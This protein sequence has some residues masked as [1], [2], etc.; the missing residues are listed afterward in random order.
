MRRLSL[1]FTV[2]CVVP[3]FGYNSPK[4]YDGTIAAVG[5]IEG[6]WREVGLIFLVYDGFSPEIDYTFRGKTWDVG[7]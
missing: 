5:T 6:T 1:M 4:E 7:G 3:L 2:L